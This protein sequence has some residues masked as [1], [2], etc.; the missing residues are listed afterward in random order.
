MQKNTNNRNTVTAIAITTLLTIGGAA[1]AGEGSELEQ[2][3]SYG[4]GNWQAQTTAPTRGSDIDQSDPYGSGNWNAQTTTPT[5]GSDL[6]QNDPSGNGNWTAQ[7]TEALNSRVADTRR[8]QSRLCRTGLIRDIVEIA[9][10]VD[11]NCP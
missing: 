1:W 4:S 7:R 11:L 5:R 3:D 10:N 2:R 6:D 9:L 8:L